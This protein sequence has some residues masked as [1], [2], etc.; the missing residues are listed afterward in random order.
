M[1]WSVRSFRF[2]TNDMRGHGDVSV[3]CC[4]SVS[5]LCM[6]RFANGQHVNV[7]IGLHW[8]A[9]VLTKKADTGFGSVWC[10]LNCFQ[11]FAFAARKG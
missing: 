6:L 7:C 8:N 2:R 9:Y 10:S 1:C 5:E 11:L 3:N 4:T